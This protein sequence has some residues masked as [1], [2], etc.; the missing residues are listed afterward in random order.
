MTHFQKLSF[1]NK[2]KTFKS[3]NPVKHRVGFEP[4]TFLFRMQRFNPLSLIQGNIR[5]YKFP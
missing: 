3:S 5:K 2:G 1:C 4:L